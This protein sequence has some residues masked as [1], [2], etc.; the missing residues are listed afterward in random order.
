MQ[1]V[2]T[3][4]CAMNHAGQRDVQSAPRQHHCTI[5]RQCKVSDVVLSAQAVFV[6]SHVRMSA[7][8]RMG[9]ATTKDGESRCNERNT[10]GAH[11]N[12]FRQWAGSVHSDEYKRRPVEALVRGTSC[13]NKGRTR[14]D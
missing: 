13:N 5:G 8:E 7:D 12:M 1:A 14:L 10:I 6:R 2:K 3:C 11:L 4:V 9:V